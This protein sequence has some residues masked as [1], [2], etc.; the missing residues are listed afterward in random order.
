MNLFLLLCSFLLLP[1]LL[2]LMVA[3]YQLLFFLIGE[4]KGIPSMYTIDVET[5]LRRQTKKQHFFIFILFSQLRTAWWIA[6]C[7]L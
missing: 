2:L 6:Y 7:R 1:L 3:F 5:K 4:M